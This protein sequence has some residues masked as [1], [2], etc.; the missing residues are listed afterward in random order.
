MI[1]LT[2]YGVKFLVLRIVCNKLRFLCTL[3]VLVGT[4]LLGNW[5]LAGPYGGPAQYITIDPQNPATL[6]VGSV[7][8]LVYRSTDSGST[9]ARLPFPRHFS[10]TIRTLLIDSKDS[11]H[12]FA[13]VQVTGANGAGLY[14]SRDAGET[15]QSVS[16]LAGNSVE[17]IA[18]F[19]GDS[20][21]LAVGTRNGGWLSTDNG[22]HWTRITPKE[23]AELLFVTA[24]AF[25]PTNADIFYLGTSHLPWKTSDGGKTW[26]P[27]NAGMIDDS[28]VFSVSVNP[29]SPDNVFASA[30]SGIYRSD[31]GGD[32]WIRAIGIPMSHRRTRVITREPGTPETIFA[33]TT[34]GL[35]RSQDGGVTWRQMN[36]QDVNS[37]AF[38]PTD[39]KTFY[40]ATGQGGIWKSTNGGETMQPLNAGFVS[41]GIGRVVSSGSNLYANTLQG[42]EFGGI[43]VSADTGKSWKLLAN[44]E[45]LTDNQI[46]G[47]YGSNKL[48]NILYA[49]SESR[50]LKSIDGGKT[51]AQ[52]PMPIPLRRPGVYRPAFRLNSLYLMGTERPVLMAATNSGLFRSNNG[53]VAWTEVRVGSQ[54]GLAALSIHAAEGGRTLL[55]R[56]PKSL[57]VSIDAAESWQELPPPVNTA[58]IYDLAVTEGNKGPILAGTAEGIYQSTDS[59]KSWT[60]RNSGIGA[61]TVASVRYHPIRTQEAYAVQFG[62][63]Y[64][65]IDSGTTWHAVPGAVLRDTFI[66]NLSFFSEAPERLFAVTPDT[67]LI[68]LDLIG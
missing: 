60:L 63:L 57:F 15:W 36:K 27:I 35:F 51:W 3:A 58:L 61:E 50:I 7:N 26:R 19:P 20:T 17:A 43:Y 54:Y 49:A 55:I 59:G 9:W 66:K 12:Y 31:T 52:S 44:A 1:I 14:E 38:S 67:G 56:T 33:G 39:P 30:C 13:G 62:R 5:Q 25:H 6:L 22:A 18:A 8:S 68:F 21:R 2:Q 40:A 42:A 48:R 37:I 41:R 46:L 28:D 65:S 16:D 4:P 32:R 23:N 64:R 10:G 45:A 34:L 47:I 53:G 24:V 29:K 11:R